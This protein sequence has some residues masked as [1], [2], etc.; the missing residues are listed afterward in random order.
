[1]PQTQQPPK[2]NNPNR[3]LDRERNRAHKES[4]HDRGSNT[5]AS[6]CD[7]L[8]N[9][10]KLLDIWVPDA[11]FKADGDFYR[12]KFIGDIESLYDNLC[13]LN[14]K[15][16]KA[17][18][19]AETPLEDFCKGLLENIKLSCTAKEHTIVHTHEES[20]ILEYTEVPLLTYDSGQQIDIEFVRHLPDA[21][22]RYAIYATISYI[23]N[24]IRCPF[25]N[26]VQSYFHDYMSEELRERYENEEDAITKENIQLWVNAHDNKGII[27]ALTTKIFKLN[28]SAKQVKRLAEKIKSK[29]PDLYKWITDAVALGEQKHKLWEF[30]LNPTDYLNENGMPVC[31]SDM[32]GFYWHRKDFIFEMTNEWQ[33]MNANELGVLPPYCYGIYNKNKK[34]PYKYTDWPTKIYEWFQNGCKI[35]TQ[36]EKKNNPEIFKLQKA[37]TASDS[38]LSHKE[39]LPTT[40]EM[41]DIAT[42]KSTLLS[43][44]RG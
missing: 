24:K 28:P 33:E 4:R 38:T 5:F 14:P 13:T 11:L 21:N 7:R 10:L 9:D 20:A 6:S 3:G 29:Y 18:I 26:N 12:N 1:M 2:R 42:L 16:K 43:M 39:L 41:E 32:M 34:R 22:V 30:D 36:I 44:G 27:D 23:T 40:K 35:L 25:F 31:Y 8:V 37:W 15:F 17:K 19:D